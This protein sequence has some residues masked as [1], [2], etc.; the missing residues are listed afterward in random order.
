MTFHQ[1]TGRNKKQDVGS[2]T[3][4][5]DHPTARLMQKTDFSF[6]IFFP[7]GKGSIIDS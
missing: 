5:A 1:A 4:I 7:H 6:P 2:I 3:F